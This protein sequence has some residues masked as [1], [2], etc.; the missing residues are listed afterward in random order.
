[1]RRPALEP[2]FG[3]RFS[4]EQKLSSVRNLDRSGPD[5]TED[6]LNAEDVEARNESEIEAEDTFQMTVKI[7][8]R[9]GRGVVA[10]ED[11]AVGAVGPSSLGFGKPRRVA[12]FPDRNRS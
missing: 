7:E 4:H 12:E 6:R 1:M 11:S 10:S 8:T 2:S 3:Q 9:R 5:F